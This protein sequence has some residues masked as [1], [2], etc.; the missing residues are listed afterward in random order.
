MLY[1]S[2]IAQPYVR[3]RARQHG[4]CC[5]IIL[6]VTSVLLGTVI[7]IHDANMISDVNYSIFY[8]QRERRCFDV[9]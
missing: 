6:T 4:D 5:T 3:E 7:I 8:L 2:S 9:I 1:Y